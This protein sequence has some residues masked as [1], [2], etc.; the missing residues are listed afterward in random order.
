MIFSMRKNYPVNLKCGLFKPRPW[1][2]IEESFKKQIYLRPL[3]CSNCK[4]KLR[5]APT[6]IMDTNHKIC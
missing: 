1:E 2:K 3:K 4:L 6:T 5:N